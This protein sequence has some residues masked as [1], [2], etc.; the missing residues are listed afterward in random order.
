MVENTLEKQQ[1]LFR[2]LA[3]NNTYNKL[4]NNRNVKYQTNEQHMD[5]VLSGY[6]KILG[7]IHRGIQ[8]QVRLIKHNY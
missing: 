3:L 6:N 2:E 5:K 8:T 7:F 4:V 1:D